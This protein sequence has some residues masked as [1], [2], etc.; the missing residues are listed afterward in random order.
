MAGP[1]RSKTLYLIVLLALIAL[2]LRPVA[3]IEG[4]A[5]RLFAPS[6]ALG[7]L[8]MPLAALRSRPLRAAEREQAERAE[9][10]AVLLD[11]QQASRPNDPALLPGRGLVPVRYVER[12]A[13]NRDAIVVRA[14]AGRALAPGAPIVCGDVF[15]G[16]VRA[17]AG[18]VELAPGEAVVDLVTARSF[19]VGARVASP[20][21][22]E[23][24]VGGLVDA[25]DEDPGGL[26]LAARAQTD[27]EASSGRAVVWEPDAAEPELGLADGFLLG[28][29][30]AYQQNGDDVLGVRAAIDYSGGLH[31]MFALAPAGTVDGEASIALDPFEE[32]SWIDCRAVAALQ[33]SSWRAGRRLEAGSSRAVVAGSAVAVG[34]RWIGDV[35][36]V[37][38]LSSTVALSGDPG[39]VVHVLAR[40]DGSARPV[41]LGALEG[42]GRD[43]DVALYRWK[44]VL[45]LPG[46]GAPLG[47]TLYTSSERRLVPP[48]LKIGR[49]EL[50]RGRGV[51]LLRVEVSA[52]EELAS[53]VRVW[54]SAPTD[55]GRP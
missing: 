17:D 42:V 28:E 29:L 12:V 10:L 19:R 31:Q 11:E 38:P 21:P 52:E 46:S 43:G 23:L 55:E 18:R 37:G 53:R 30:A 51:F 4:F 45:P 49:A 54:R 20:R 34:A 39:L 36:S 48:G 16:R 26:Y 22:V 3:G 7:T 27:R 1:A 2:S 9:C 41:A 8:V 33:P 35:A 24:V 6:R 15:V 40:V 32:P 5:E 44:A 13:K 25:P 47:A 14:P 50:P